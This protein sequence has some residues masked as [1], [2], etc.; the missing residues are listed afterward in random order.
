MTTQLPG[1]WI[2]RMSLGAVRYRC[3]WCDAEVASRDGYRTNVAPQA[4]IALCPGCNQPTYMHNNAQTPGPLPG[5]PV[6]KLPQGIDSL[7]AEARRAIAANAHTAAVLSFRKLLMH[8]AV[9]EGAAA[10]LNFIQYV[11]YL[12]GK[13]F[14]PPKGKGWVDHIRTKGNE[15]NHEIVLMTKEDAERLCTFT[16]MLLR[17]MY[18]FPNLVPPAQ[19]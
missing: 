7:Y 18:E 11:E 6:A 19:P 2:N 15:A 12:D 17:F 3:G 4:T 16:E 8:L 9:A 1:E 14:V 13:G 10:N 5:K